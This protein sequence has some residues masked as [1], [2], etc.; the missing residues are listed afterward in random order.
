MTAGP[1]SRGP[2]ARLGCE[3]CL[4][5]VALVLGACADAAAR[6][7]PGVPSASAIAAADVQ[8]TTERPTGS[9]LATKVCTTKAQRDAMAVATRDANDAMQRAHG[10]ACPGT[11]GCA[12]K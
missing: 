8:C 2:R 11:P 10:P 6:R 4:P 3:L 5:V 12:S 7:A 9:M 1:H